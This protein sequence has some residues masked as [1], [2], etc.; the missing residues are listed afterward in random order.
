MTS[1]T[2]TNVEQATR[3]FIQSV[4]FETIPDVDLLANLPHVKIKL[5]I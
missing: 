5:N 1:K 4:L 2:K 3:T